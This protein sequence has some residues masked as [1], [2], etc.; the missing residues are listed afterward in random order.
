MTPWHSS[1]AVG[2]DGSFKTV[3]VDEV[4]ETHDL[5]SRN[6]QPYYF[7][8]KSDLF[9]FG[10][11]KVEFEHLYPCGLVIRPAPEVVGKPS[12][13]DMDVKKLRKLVEHQS[14]VV[15]RGF[16]DTTDRELYV[17]KG[18]ELGEVLPWSFGIVQEVKDHGRKDKLHNNVESNEA[19]PMH[20]DGIFKFVPKKDENGNDMKD[21]S[22]NEIKIQK[23]PK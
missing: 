22:G 1:I 15:L 6:G 17:S 13:R 10:E 4:R 20:Y 16:S 14:P 9:D 11:I 5:V 18:H 23:P 7:R 8:E 12:F 19:M 3:H 21:G 2:I